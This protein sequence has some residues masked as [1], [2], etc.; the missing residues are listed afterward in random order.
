MLRSD[1]R[2]VRNFGLLSGSHKKRLPQKSCL[3]KP[4][5]TSYRLGIFGSLAVVARLRRTLD[6][7]L[8]AYAFRRI[9][10][11]RNA[12]SVVNASAKRLARP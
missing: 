1:Q 3:R 10:P 5:P 2:V 11:Y 4:F 9:C 6:P 12:G 7:V 8:C